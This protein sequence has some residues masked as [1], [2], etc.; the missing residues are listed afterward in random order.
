MIIKLNTLNEFKQAKKK[1]SNKSKCPW[2]NYMWELFKSETY[3]DTE[4]DCFL[5][6][7]KQS[8]EL[9]KLIE[10]ISTK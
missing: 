2:S 1:Y 6:N 10:E 7:N 5:S 3:Y 4:E 8:E 9:Q